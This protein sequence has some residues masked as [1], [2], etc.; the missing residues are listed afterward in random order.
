[1]MDH[2]FY[3]EMDRYVM[4][5]KAVVTILTTMMSV[6]ISVYDDVQISMHVITTVQRHMTTDL[7]SRLL[8]V[9]SHDAHETLD[10]LLC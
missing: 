7:V 4:V 6:V 5:L 8:A 10:H 3:V 1:M 9:I 2:A